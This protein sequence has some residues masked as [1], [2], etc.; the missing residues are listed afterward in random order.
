MLSTYA[1]MEKIEF[2]IW[3]FQTNEDQFFLMVNYSSILFALGLSWIRMCYNLM[4]VLKTSCNK[5]PSN[6]NFFYLRLIS[7]SVFPIISYI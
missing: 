7:L 3:V 1:N 2:Y 4:I 5:L 6:R